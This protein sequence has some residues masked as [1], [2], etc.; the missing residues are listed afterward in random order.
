MIRQRKLAIIQGLKVRRGG[1]IMDYRVLMVGAVLLVMAAIAHSTELSGTC[2]NTSI[3]CELS[4][5]NMQVCNDSSATENYSAY[6]SGQVGSWFNVIPNKFTLESDECTE[7]KVYTV[8]NC[9]ADP[10]TYSTQLI[11]Q[12]GETLSTTCTFN[13]EQGHFLDVEVE[14]RSQTAS[15]CEEKT[16]EIMVTNNTIVQNQTTE[17]ADISV[18]GLS[19]G[20]Y[21]LSESTILV[22]KGKTETLELTVKAPCDA[23]FG[24][25]DF[26]VRAST[27]N[28]NFYDE[29]SAE[30]NLVQG[31]GAQIISE[32]G[33]SGIE[34]RACVEEASEAKI[35]IVNNG[36]LEDNFKLTLTGPSFAKLDKTSLSLEAGEEEIVT[37]KFAQTS[38]KAG[39]YDLDLELESTL[40]D[41]STSKSYTVNLQDCYNIDVQKTLGEEKLCAEDTPVYKFRL[42]NNESKTVDLDISFTGVETNPKTQ[43]I[44]IEPGKTK[45]IS[46]TLDIASLTRQAQVSREDVSVELLVDT[47]GSMAERTG[48]QL[49]I[50]AAKTA[51]INL[52]NNINQI[53]LGLRVFGQGTE[54]EESALL[55]PISKLDIASITDKVSTF[56]PLGKTP[57]AQALDAAGNDFSAGKKKVLIIVS[58]G[59]E[60]CEGDVSQAA[61]DLAQNGITAYAIG[62]DID[63]DGKKQLQEVANRTKGKYY[64]AKGAAELANV[65]KQI[66]QE[67]D[68]TLGT[69]AKKNLTLKLDSEHFTFEKDYAIEVSDCYTAALTV[70]ELNVCGGVLKTDYFT[71]ANIGTKDQEFEIKYTPP[72]VDGPAK[73]LVKAGESSKQ[74][75]HATMPKGSDEK[76]F[77]I[78]ATSATISLVQEENINMLSSASCY[79]IDIIL[80]STE[81]DAATC[82]GQ[83]QILTIEN[84][85]AAEQEVTVTADKP[86]VYVVDG[87]ITLKSG[88]RREV[89]YFVSPPFD[90][91][92]TTF[93]TFT[94]RTNNGFET[95]SVLKLFVEGN[96]ESFGLGEIDIRVQDLNAQRITDV[97]YNI[98]VSF[99]LYNDSNRTLTVFNARALDF[100]GAVAMEGRTIAPKGTAKSALYVKIPDANSGRTYTVP[101]SIESDE[102]TYTRNIVFTLSDQNVT[103][104]VEAEERI[105]IGTG[106]F[107]LAN[108]STAVLGILI[109]LVIGLIAYSSYRAVRAEPAQKTQEIT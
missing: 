100:N 84:R 6:F 48:D 50:D 5:K 4:I 66:S 38:Q 91:P 77:S 8:A 109:I 46:T 30:Y 22:R 56:R 96:E 79:G 102:G 92:A 51:V 19:A 80:Q 35:R 37:V 17:R 40:Y 7:L 3:Q 108:I 47:S 9:Y 18:I 26:T 67:L 62:F 97:N 72:F 68:I 74:Q 44:S 43:K 29:D 99:N 58:D 31:Q 27:P 103:A 54:C 57:L 1:N 13:L 41:Y 25:Y 88:E 53:D 16:Y 98:K 90:L 61:R 105:N 94:A 69:N 75:F 52:V 78:S 20:W 63:A 65:L 76:K 101:I 15:Q 23:E 106:L 2:D 85:G 82:E 59:K 104:P 71:I 28:P 89:N 39:E 42:T 70:P 55:R 95:Q 64:D 10:G 36:K 73:V 14:P 49:K 60:T 93:I 11:V 87:K 21:T 24:N 33:F 81:L 34:A 12:N 45:E 107:S 32:S 86:Y 83:K